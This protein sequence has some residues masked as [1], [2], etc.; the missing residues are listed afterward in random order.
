MPDPG[1]VR[2]PSGRYQQ[3]YF[4]GT[5]WTEHVADEYG[6]RSTDPVENAQRQTTAPAAA[7]SSPGY[8]TPGYGTPSTAVATYPAAPYQP[9]AATGASAPSAADDV[10]L[11]IS[12]RSIVGAVGGL[13]AL[14]G[15]VL[16]P[17]F[18]DTRVVQM[19]GGSTTGLLNSTF[20][21]TGWIITVVAIFFSVAASV[22][23]TTSAPRWLAS[24][25]VGVCVVWAVVGTLVVKS[26]IDGLSFGFG[27]FV[28]VVGLIAATVAPL[29]PASTTRG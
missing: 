9:A 7:P 23:T 22:R 11:E 27:F 15:I 17:W 8:G 26:D 10:A 19:R 29:L 13:V 14:I 6:R 28:A 3:R 5:R 20:F 25:P 16:C 21:E 12:V 24:I 2:D 4:D 1:W 18:T